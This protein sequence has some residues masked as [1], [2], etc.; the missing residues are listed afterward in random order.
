MGGHVLRTHRSPQ[1]A[2]RCAGAQALSVGLLPVGMEMA[3]SAF[4]VLL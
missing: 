2:E 4:A 1:I 3:P